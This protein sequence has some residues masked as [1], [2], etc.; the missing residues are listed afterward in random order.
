ME[1]ECQHYEFIW[2]EKELADGRIVEYRAWV[3]KV[4]LKERAS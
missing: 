4:C 3:C 2:V 1:H